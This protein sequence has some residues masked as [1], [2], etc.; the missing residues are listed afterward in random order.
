MKK[1]LKTICLKLSGKIDKKIKRDLTEYN[2][3]MK[4]KEINF[5]YKDLKG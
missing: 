5:L 4:T 3:F 2:K 1:N